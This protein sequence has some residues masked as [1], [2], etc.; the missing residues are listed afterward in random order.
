MEIRVVAYNSSHRE[1]LQLYRDV[2]KENTALTDADFETLKFLD[3]PIVCNASFARDK[4]ILQKIGCPT[5]PGGA[6]ILNV[7]Y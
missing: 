5:F 2:L 1:Q 4:G 3:Q 6:L 7:G